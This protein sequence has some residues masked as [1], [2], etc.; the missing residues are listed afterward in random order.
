VSA[1]LHEIDEMD[2]QTEQEMTFAFY[3]AFVASVGLIVLTI[4]L[5]FKP[6]S[7]SPPARRWVEGDGPRAL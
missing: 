7:E 3:S 1:P 6:A 2:D 5:E 4:G